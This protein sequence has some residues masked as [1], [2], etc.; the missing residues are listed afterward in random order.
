MVSYSQRCIF[1]ASGDPGFPF[2]ELFILR[3]GSVFYSCAIVKRGQSQMRF[4][5]ANGINAECFVR[6]DDCLRAFLYLEVWTP[7]PIKAFNRERKRVA[8]T[9][10]EARNNDERVA[11][12]ASG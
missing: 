11:I 6:V 8:S 5:H 10:T 7:T 2:E 12:E 9:I 3:S 4:G 1:P